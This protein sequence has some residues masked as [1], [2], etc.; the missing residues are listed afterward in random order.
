MGLVVLSSCSG[1]GSSATSTST[2]TSTSTTAART[3]SSVAGTSTTVATT[4]STTAAPGGVL[5]MTATGF[6]PVQLGMT[7]AQATATGLLQGA[8]GPGCELANPPQHG[9]QLV[10]AYDGTVTTQGGKVTAIAVHLQYRTDPGSIQ[11]GDSLSQVQ[12]AFGSG[13]TVTV[14]KAGEQT[15]GSWFVHVVHGTTPIFTFVVDPGTQK[16][17]EAGLPDVQVCD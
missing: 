6:G 10:A 14:D 4:T 17:V 5:V 2:S 8:F 12:G 7:E 15:F 13:Y 1:G 16:V 9:A 11:T 3:A